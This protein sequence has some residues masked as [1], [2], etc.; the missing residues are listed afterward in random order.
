[1]H[2]FRTSYKDRQGRKRQAAKWYVEFY[3]HLEKV[4]RLPGFTDKRQT[5]ELGRKIEKLVVCRTNSEAPD[6][7]LCRWLD[8]LSS[9]IRKRL[10]ALGLIS[11]TK[12]AAGRALTDHL[13]DFETSLLTNGGLERHARQTATRVRK[14]VADCGFRFWSEI[15]ASKV[16]KYLADL[17]TGSE[18]L[19]IQTVNFYLQAVKQFAKWMV[20]NRRASESPLDHLKSQNV[21]TDRRHDRRALSVEEL[22]S[23]LESTRLGVSRFG[24]T[25]TQRAVLYRLA[26]ESGLRA[27]ELQSLTVGSFNLDTQPPTVTV[28]AGYSKRRRE[29]VLPLRPNM[30]ED[31]KLL[32][33]RKRPQTAA[34][35]LPRGDKMVHM[36]RADL[37][38]ARDAWVANGLSEAERAARRESS[39]LSY[40]DEAGLVADF[41]SLRHSFI[42]NLA[43]SGVH[44]KLAQS[45]ARHS[46]INLTL[47]RYS[48]TTTGEQSDALATLPDLSPRENS[49]ATGA[50]EGSGDS[51]VLGCSLAQKH[52]ESCPPV[53][54]GALTEA[55][56][57]A[58]CDHENDRE[59]AVIPAIPGV[60]NSIRLAGIGPATY[61]LGNR[62][63]IH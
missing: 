2:V 12:A 6:K 26:V 4:R 1:M 27:N 44:P 11:Q 39:Y 32:F 46:D 59:N 14:L 56:E 37:T 31:L 35:S 19:S 63:S 23:L 7:D 29:D 61:G 57:A 62:C 60:E 21:R 40:R 43:R 30:V 41:H 51:S 58:L 47:S 25:G 18:R 33:G 13:D 34:F 45:L 24:M 16:E 42:S 5:E 53:L 49:N 50:K 52:A 20:S 55:I 17:R 8:G 3:D 48:H 9:P 38:S 28:K 15:S 54:L 22:R 36:M 10:A